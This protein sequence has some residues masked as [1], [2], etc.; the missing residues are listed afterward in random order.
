[1]YGTVARI[2]PLPGKES[3]TIAYFRYWDEERKPRVPGAIGGYACHLSSD[4]GTW[5]FVYVFIDKASYEANA[6]SPAMDTDYHRLRAL[7]SA[8]PIWEDGDMIAW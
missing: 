3:E 1:M 4:P 5:V 2:R 7:L 8:D 6:Q